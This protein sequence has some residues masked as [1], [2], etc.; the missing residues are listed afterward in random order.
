MALLTYLHLEVLVS[1]SPQMPSV[2]VEQMDALLSSATDA[3]ITFVVGETRVHAHRIMLIARSDYFKTMLTSGFSE[4]QAHQIKIGDTTPEAFRAIL[5]YLYTDEL[6][7]TDDLLV[8]VMRKAKEMQ[9]ERVYNYSVRRCRR[10]IGVHNCV[11]WFVK[12][13]AYGLEELRSATF[14]YL[15]R[16]FRQVK[17]QARRTLQILSDKPHL[18]MEVMLEAI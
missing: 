12:A 13:D 3:D 10:G 4:G 1:P 2:F 17:A 6:N 18:L 5:R 8:D 16:N 14:G 11:A 9:L 15:S 7:F